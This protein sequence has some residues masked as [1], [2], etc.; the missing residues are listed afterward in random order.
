MI[1][2]ASSNS[3]S[4]HRPRRR[5]IGQT[6]ASVELMTCQ[7]SHGRILTMNKNLQKHRIKAGARFY[8]PEKLGSGT[9]VRLPIDTAHHAIR[10]L[11]LGVGDPIVLFDDL[12]GE[13]EASICRIDR[14][15]VVAKTGPF[16]DRNAESPLTLTL[17]QGISTSERMDF[18]I[19][20]AVELGISVIQ[21]LATE[22]SVVK[23]TS[24]RAVRKT[25]HWRKLAIAACEQCGR[26]RLPEIA[27]PQKLP[28][29]LG[30]QPQ[31]GGENELRLLLAPDADVGINDLPAKVDRIVL[32]VGPEGGLAPTEIDTA[33]LRGFQPVRLGPRVLRTETAA[34][35]ALAAIQ[36]RWGD[37]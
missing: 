25:G 20:K 18:T 29:W 17:A 9:E 2:G 21:P 10:A 8:F 36:L 34:L 32:M 3:V 15:L 27:D 5:D 4:F 14:D 16:V 1:V 33:R 26:N 28:D 7:V 13:Y 22:R 6:A 24:E 19:Q 31:D 30:L 23:L 37:F 35:V 12:G 11:R